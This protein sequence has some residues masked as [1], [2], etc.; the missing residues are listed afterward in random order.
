MSWENYDEG[1]IRRILD[2]EDAKRAKRKE[3][4]ISSRDRKQTG[5]VGIKEA[6]S[7]ESFGEKFDLEG[8]GSSKKKKPYVTV[9]N[10]SADGLVS[11][12]YD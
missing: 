9:E 2:E 11:E 6:L 3:T 4:R 12:V 7:V 1:W 8:C 10:Y 5:I